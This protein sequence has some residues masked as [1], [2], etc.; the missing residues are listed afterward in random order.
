MALTFKTPGVHIIE[1]TPPGPIEAVGTSTAA[2]IGPAVAGPMRKPTLIANWNTFVEKFGKDIEVDGGTERSPYSSFP[3]RLYTPIA[4]RGFFDN[5]GQTAYIVRVGTGAH[6]VLDLEDRADESPFSVTPG[7][8]PTPAPSLVERG[9]A[10]RMQ[11]KKE[12]K[13]G[14]LISVQVNDSSLRITELARASSLITR[15]PVGMIKYL[16]KCFN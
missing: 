11:A 1:V 8:P 10:L 12:G 2:F 5:G 3:K 13:Q 16:L 14:D 9:T 7:P 6:S 4:V 15:S